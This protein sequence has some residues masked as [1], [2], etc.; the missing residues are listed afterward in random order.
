MSGEPFEPIGDLARW[1]QLVPLFV[2]TPRGSTVTHE[3]LAKAL[4]LDPESETDRKA[5]R[6]AVRQA[7]IHLSREHDR[8]LSAVR[9][10]GYRVARADE[11]VELASGQQRRSRRALSRAKQHVD[12]VDLSE[13]SEEGRRIVHAAASALAWQQQQIRKLDL[14]QAGL[15]RVVESIANKA[16]V[17][18]E[19][20]AA[21]EREIAELREHDE[22]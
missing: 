4:D 6:A 18:D 3:E 9:G 12:H 13:L 19:R 20:L 15:E 1:R 14:R 22:H 2:E 17:T 5:I 10:V 21:L 16:D 8:S 11:H 7:A